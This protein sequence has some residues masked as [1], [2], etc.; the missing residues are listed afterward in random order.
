MTR[1]LPSIASLATLAGTAAL[2]ASLHAQVPVFRAGA[3]AVLV[4]VQV[5]QGGRPV[6]GLTANDF[7]LLD[8]NVKQNVETT[9]S[10]SVPFDLTMVLD[11]SGSVEGK[12]LDRLKAGVRDMTQLL[13]NEDRWRVIAVDHVLHEI[14]PL[15]SPGKAAAIDALQPG[16]G[17]ALY[18]GL[19]AGLTP[20]RE[21]GRRRM[22]MAYTD[23][24]DA[25]S[26]TST[27]ALLDVAR[28]SDSVI[29]VVVPVENAAAR[30]QGGSPQ[31]ASRATTPDALIN[32]AV[33]RQ[34]LGTPAGGGLFPNES[35]FTDLTS[36]TGGR[37]FVVDY[38][39]SAGAAFRRVMDAYRTSYVLRYARDGVAAAGWHELTV[40]VKRAG[41]YDV[42]ARKGYW[43]N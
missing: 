39:E 15:Q 38:N 36:R 30:M 43:G 16:G 5:L 41:K 3:D 12:R 19:I 35:L 24:D 17:T 28:L 25:S 26:I 37:V 14:V 2:A 29:H 7:E 11:T 10:T 34:S 8:N 1:R 20:A 6:S 42:L 23:G 33:S 13:R 27:T 18:D 21:P 31:L 32:Q 4:D 9:L 22:L 40:H